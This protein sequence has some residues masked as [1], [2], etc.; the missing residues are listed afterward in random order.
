MPTQSTVNKARKAKRE[1][2]S[3]S[4]QA[5]VFVK[6]EMDEIRSGK[7]GARSPKQA[8]AIGLS[9]ARRAG[10]KV[11]PAPKGSKSAKKKSA[12]TTAHRGKKSAKRS[13]SALSKHAHEAAHHRSA[14][15]RHESAMKAVRTKGKAGL[16][17]AAHKAAMTREHH[18][19]A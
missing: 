15:S 4:T 17:R 6:K 9:E 2:K 1:G 5:G 8:I 12:S 16:R 7:H 10:V 13:T 19:H 11:P 18:A 14:R 3:P